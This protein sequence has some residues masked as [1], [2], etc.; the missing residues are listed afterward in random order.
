MPPTVGPLIETPDDTVVPEMLLL[1]LAAPAIPP[2][3]L[4]APVALIVVLLTVEFEI[5]QPFKAT[6]PPTSQLAPVER[7]VELETVT[8]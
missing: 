3:S 8:F 5:D 7:I 4:A 6:I 1:E 2:T